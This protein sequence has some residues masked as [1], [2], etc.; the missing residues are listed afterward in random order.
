MEK[1]SVVQRMANQSFK[2]DMFTMMLQSSKHFVKLWSLPGRFVSK[3]GEESNTEPQH[4]PV[5]RTFCSCLYNFLSSIEKK[6]TYLVLHA[7]AIVDPFDWIGRYWL[8]LYPIRPPILQRQQ[9]NLIG[10][11]YM[12][13]NHLSINHLSESSHVSSQY[14][15]ITEVVDRDGHSFQIWVG[16]VEL[17][18]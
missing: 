2:I 1:S 13:W 8:L 15:R 18:G 5:S 9:Q 6:H 16:S 14:L 7:F 4:R 3:N 12:N 17:N 11:Y 10:D